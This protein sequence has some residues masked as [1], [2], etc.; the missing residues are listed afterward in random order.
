[1][2]PNASQSDLLRMI[3]RFLINSV[4]KRWVTGSLVTLLL[5]A[6]FYGWT[7]FKD[8]LRN[9]GTN[10]CIQLINEATVRDLE[11]AL[12][13][14]RI[15]NTQLRARAVATAQENASLRARLAQAQQRL[16][17]FEGELRVQAE[18]DET[19]REWADTDLPDGVVDRLRSLQ[20]RN[21]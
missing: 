9:E 16:Q 10:E 14:E 19:Y 2:L 12:T 8:G 7:N 13:A 1:M 5:G 18:E 20:S 6:G 4:T 3:L 21:N 17:W 11:N 15:T